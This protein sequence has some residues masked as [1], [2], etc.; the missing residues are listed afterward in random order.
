MAEVVR[1]R[2]VLAE[3]VARAGTVEN[4]GNIEQPRPYW[5]SV[6]PMKSG[7]DD[8]DRPPAV[9]ESSASSFDSFIRQHRSALDRRAAFLCRGHW[10]ADDLVQTTLILA[11]R[12]Y[13][14]LRDHQR[15]RAWL[16]R[17]LWRAFLDLVRGWRNEPPREP[18]EKSETVP[19]PMDTIPAW[20]KLTMEQLGACVDRLPDEL[21]KSY[22]LFAFEGCDYRSIARKL[23]IPMSTVGTRLLRAR[24]A[25]KEMLRPLVSEE[26]P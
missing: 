19:L 15:G 10:D 2:S 23:N 20:A 9:A 26:A 25:L 5:Y 8:P 1:P 6:A 18:V 12:N 13:A 11:A 3:L 17:I 7:A 22:R 14:S 4:Y 21:Q 24:K 16:L